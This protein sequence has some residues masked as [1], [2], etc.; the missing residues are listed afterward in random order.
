MNQI[1][2]K[3]QQLILASVSPRRRDI[4][5]AMGI[6]F[7]VVPPLEEETPTDG[8]DAV[9]VA[10]GRAVHKVRA[11]AA[12]VKEGTVI[13]ADTVVAV[14]SDILGKPATE[15]MAGQFLRRLRGKQHRVITALALIDTASGKELTDHRISRVFMRQYSDDEIA[16]YVARG[17]PW[18][19]AGAYAIQDTQ[20]HLVA[21]VAGCYLNVVG[22]PVC[23]SLRLLS[24]MGI[25][26]TIDPDWMPPGDCS[27]CAHWV[28]LRQVHQNKCHG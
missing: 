13:A 4:L 25:H 11:V 17:N 24:Q 12:R 3:S 1:A 28:S 16:D 18:D 5:S 14:G 22:L 19:K 27:D 8:G 7:E 10:L 15:E 6:A 21:R 20:F 9:A 2:Q 23:T 26:P